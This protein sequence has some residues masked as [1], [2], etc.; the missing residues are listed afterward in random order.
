MSEF[1][2]KKL[3]SGT[4]A[5]V[6]SRRQALAIAIPAAERACGLKVTRAPKKNVVKVK[7]ERK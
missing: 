5:T 1:K 2:T 4:G 7:R 6:K 3:K